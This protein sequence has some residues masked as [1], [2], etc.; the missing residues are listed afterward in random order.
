MK[1]QKPGRAGGGAGEVFVGITEKKQFPGFRFSGG[2]KLALG[3]GK[4]RLQEKETAFRM[5]KTR[6]FVIC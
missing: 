1:Q 3:R 5:I 4:R 6:G 2:W